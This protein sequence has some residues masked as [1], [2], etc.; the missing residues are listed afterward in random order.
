M[1]DNLKGYENQKR[2][3][4]NIIATNAAGAANAE[5]R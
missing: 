3:L 2:E 4:E 1:Q 5:V